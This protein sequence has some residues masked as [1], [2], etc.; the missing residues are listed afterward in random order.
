[1]ATAQPTEN[2]RDG[3]RFDMILRMRDIS[4]TTFTNSSRGTEYPPMEYLSNDHLE[5]PNQHQNSHDPWFETGHPILSL[6]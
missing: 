6:L 2:H 1:M 4:L 5:H 3:V